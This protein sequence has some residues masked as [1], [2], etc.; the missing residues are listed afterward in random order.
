MN[1]IILYQ[2]DDGQSKIELQLQ[3]GTV[4]LNQLELAELFQT[5]RQNI[6][7]HIKT[8]FA[9]GE[10]DEKVVSKNYL[11]TT[12]HGALIDKTQTKEAKELF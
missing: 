7:L 6:A 10:I 11:Q 4:W 8:I 12:Q 2:T 1:D 9:D 5:T 3:D